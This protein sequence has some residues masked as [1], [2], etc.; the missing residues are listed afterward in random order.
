MSK[1]GIIGL[2][3]GVIISFASGPF[4]FRRNE[5]DPI[6]L[7]FFLIGIL[8]VMF[9]LPNIVK[10]SN[11]IISGTKILR[12]TASARASWIWMLEI[13]LITPF[14]FPKDS[15]VYNID[16]PPIMLY[17]VSSETAFE[18]EF[19]WV[20]PIFIIFWIIFFFGF[21]AS[22][23]PKT[24]TIIF[25][26][27]IVALIVLWINFAVQLTTW[28]FLVDKS[29][30]LFKDFTLQGDTSDILTS[31][32]VILIG[33]G[34]GIIS[35]IIAFRMLTKLAEAYSYIKIENSTVRLLFTTAIIVSYIAT[36]L[37]FYY[38]VQ[39]ISVSEAFIFPF[40]NFVGILFVILY[41]FKLITSIIKSA[42]ELR[43]KR[44]TGHG[45]A[46]GFNAAMFFVIFI[47]VWSPLFLGVVDGGL[48]SKNHSAYNPGWNGAS[49]FRVALQQEGYEVRTVHSSFSILERIDPSKMIILVILGP[50][51][52]YNPLS[53]IPFFLS[54][55]QQNFSMLI[56]DDHG[57]TE[58]LLF[59]LFVASMF[60]APITFLPKGILHE[61][62]TGKYWKRPE[63]PIIKDFAFHEITQGINSVCLSYGT[64]MLGGPL[65]SMMGWDTIGQTSSQYSYVDM[66]NNQMF[67]SNDTYKPPEAITQA[68]KYVFAPV[69]MLLEKGIPMGGYAQPV[70]AAKELAYAV[71]NN[72]GNLHSSRI[73]ISSDA[74]LFNNELMTVKDPA[75]NNLLFD[76][77]QFGLN[78]INWLSADFAPEDCVIV[79]DEAHIRP[80]SGI[81]EIKSTSIFGRFQGYINWLSTNPILG[82][83]YPL[84][85]LYSL[86]RWLPSEEDKKKVQLEELLEAERKRE[87]LKFRTSS[88]F[89]KKI[90]WYRVNKRYNQALSILYRRIERKLRTLYL[91]EGQPATVE[92]IMEA[93]IQAK[94]KYH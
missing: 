79:F 31:L 11:P 65:L 61:N 57:T 41:V 54:A 7:T 76:N 36:A 59:E 80:E 17:Y 50:N 60:Q 22:R 12:P 3:I 82:L 72:A 14:W 5:T 1:K 15:T 48:N 86:R 44:A 21:F 75:T 77:K 2:I 88:F 52:A 78:I 20:L 92:T 55:F 35:V 91:Q 62:E 28:A 18:E 19:S 40:A 58:T 33:I 6:A 70:F 32:P 64:S 42:N 37:P 29:G 87:I 68:V 67:D 53:E 93:V 30:T 56:A 39:I 27:I 90:N 4:A 81:N 63:F 71:P 84:L 46:F 49:E 25:N 26:T 43:R 38:A 23:W 45:S 8:V 74:S 16:G 51:V 24:L 9:S 69:G 34:Y 83:I 66:N 94:G 47:L 73:F 13:F 89:A 85:A 10:G